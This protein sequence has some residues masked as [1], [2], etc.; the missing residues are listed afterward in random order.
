MANVEDK[1]NFETISQLR[2][3]ATL[4]VNIIERELWCR[5][6]CRQKG[7]RPP[8][9]RHSQRIWWSRKDVKQG[10]KASDNAY[11]PIY[12]NRAMLLFRRLY[13]EI[14]PLKRIS[15]NPILWYLENVSDAVHLYQHHFIK[16]EP[17]S[18]LEPHAGASVPPVP[19]QEGEAMN[20]GLAPHTDEVYRRLEDSWLI[21]GMRIPIYA[22]DI[23]TGI[24]FKK[25]ALQI[26]R[27]PRLLKNRCIGLEIYHPTAH[28]E[29]S[30]S[31]VSACAQVSAI[32]LVD[33]RFN[34][35]LKEHTNFHDPASMLV[36]GLPWISISR[37]GVQ[38][39]RRSPKKPSDSTREDQF[40]AKDVDM[41][42]L[43]SE[44]VKES[45]TALSVPDTS[46]PTHHRPGST[47][48]HITPCSEFA[49]Q[50][51]SSQEHYTLALPFH[52][53]VNVRIAPVHIL[54]FMPFIEFLKEES[55]RIVKSLG[56]AT[57][58]ARRSTLQIKAPSSTHPSSPYTPQ[59]TSPGEQPTSSS[60][61][62]EYSEN[63]GVLHTSTSKGRSRSYGE[64]LSIANRSPLPRP[65]RQSGPPPVPRHKKMEMDQKLDYSH[66]NVMIGF[67]IIS[68]LIVDHRGVAFP[69]PELASMRFQIPQSAVSAITYRGKEKK[70]NVRL[71]L[72][73]FGAHLD[74]HQSI[75]QLFSLVPY[76][77]DNLLY[78]VDEVK[79]TIAMLDTR[80]WA[81]YGFLDPN[82]S[83]VDYP[84][85]DDEDAQ[86]QLNP[87]A[88]GNMNET[89]KKR[90]IRK[91]ENGKEEAVLVEASGDIMKTIYKEAHAINTKTRNQMLTE[92]LDPTGPDILQFATTANKSK[93]SSK[94][95]TSR[96]VERHKHLYIK[97]TP[98]RDPPPVTSK[99]LS[100]PSTGLLRSNT[101]QPSTDK[102]SPIVPKPSFYKPPPHVD[103]RV[104]MVARPP[105]VEQHTP[106]AGYY[107]TIWPNWNYQQ[108]QQ[109]PTTYFM[110]NMWGNRT[111]Q[112]VTTV[113]SPSQMSD[114]QRQSVQGNY[115]L[116]PPN[117]FR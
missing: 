10:W 70:E 20:L 83:G 45:S 57:M 7:I 113:P 105:W 61:I 84:A 38:R 114:Q 6:V 53:Q 87:D 43:Y 100:V 115:V 24:R 99:T 13:V 78:K 112:P 32:D 5:S 12:R 88:P 98:V 4:E 23:R 51:K 39:G 65:A 107:N 30:P 54:V 117:P 96:S 28:F 92:A 73:I 101:T 58:E 77:R 90:I 75:Q 42:R 9:D 44:R 103:N 1:F 40:Q 68:A 50:L 36:A 60:Q 80:R 67:P 34:K 52:L 94:P 27:P 37:D 104:P 69:Q 93:S 56:F 109:A 64:R 82:P 17:T 31:A 106:N 2:A 76:L 79:K 95:G 15:D 8:S 81:E 47:E 19:G 3:I 41:S 29:T 14:F 62:H 46:E 33:Y 25:I 97:E 91:G 16:N 22:R 26:C 116:Y 48:S 11:G 63:A 74:V 49:L 110:P 55:L 111:P 35:N 85:P 71:V 59:P 108:T 72:K 89:P 86:L 21:Q 66:V 18:L 102:N